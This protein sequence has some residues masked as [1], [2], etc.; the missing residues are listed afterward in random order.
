[1]IKVAVYLAGFYI[2]YY[3]F[4]SRDTLYSRN[5]LV[6][7]S[8][9]MLSFIMPLITVNI[10][11]SES[12]L[13]F[14][15]VLGEVFVTADGQGIPGTGP[16]PAHAD[17]ATILFRTYLAGIL[18]FTAKLLIDIFS[19]LYLVL[20]RKD[21]EEN[22]VRFEGFN[23]AGFSAMGYVFINSSLSEGDAREIIRHE[24][25]HLDQNHF[26]DILF[27]EV[28]KV[29]QWFN[30]FIYMVN[31]SLRAIHEYQADEGCLRSGMNVVRYQNLLLTHLF[32]SKV[33]MSANSFS[34]PSLIRKRMIMMTRVRTANIASLKLVLIIPVAI[35]LMMVFS[36]FENSIDR[37]GENQETGP[38]PTSV[39]KAIEIIRTPEIKAEAKQE[40]PT[41]PPPPPVSASGETSG[42]SR[43]ATVQVELKMDGAVDNEGRIAEEQ[44][45][46]IPSE[47]FVV[48]EEMPQF[49]GGDEALM[50]FIYNNIEYPENA[51]TNNIQGRAIIRFAV[52]ADGSVD[53]VT[54]LKGVDPS[55][56]AEAIRVIRM[57]PE[58][59]PGRQGGK[60]VNVWYSVPVTFQLK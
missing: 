51:K 36:S 19:L 38:V 37:L 45:P 40:I 16:D 14:G 59:K 10:R 11:W 31:R 32:R 46:A 29:F 28:A 58:W 35:L 3:L 55:I 20:R 17:L 43:P 30:P 34:N 26:I 33:F 44:K 52:L 53:Q 42:K 23:T 13:Y 8:S 39:S 18:V 5:R 9:V 60:P 47:V 48:V 25:N 54:V 21:R 41:P 27:I 1:M 24:Q 22:I 49:P 15:K 4:L 7:I 2:I 12:I 57:L 56:D 6:L 50:Q